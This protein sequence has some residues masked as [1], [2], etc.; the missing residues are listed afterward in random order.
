VRLNQSVS[1]ALPSISGNDGGLHPDDIG[2]LC[3][4]RNPE[5]FRNPEF[6]L[7]DSASMHNCN[8]MK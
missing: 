6:L 3:K 8:T 4:S 1:V 7:S 2:F 5:F